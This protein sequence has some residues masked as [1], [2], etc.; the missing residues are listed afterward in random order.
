MCA[1]TPVRVIV[2]A[3]RTVRRTIEV[4]ALGGT[5][6]S[7]ILPVLETCPLHEVCKSLWRAIRTGLRVWRD[8]VYCLLPT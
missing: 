5:F 2:R 4:A 3:C 1:Q 8:P 6:E 7:G